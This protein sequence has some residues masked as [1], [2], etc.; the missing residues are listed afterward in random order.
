MKH[1]DFADKFRA[2]YDQATRLYA[3]G[4]TDQAAYFTTDERAF[5]AANGI[6]V[7]AMYDYA[8]D[9]KNYGEPGYDRALQIETVR[10]DYFLN[11]QHG[12]PSTAVLDAA[13]MPAKTDAVKGI[14][15][16]PRLI[17]KAK[18][19]LRGELPSSLMYSCGGDRNFFKTHDILPAEFLALVWRNGDND[20]ATVDWVVARSAAA[21]AR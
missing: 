9:Q 17:P 8:E 7:Q 13:K 18:A 6:S 5:L 15:W 11:V 4:Q 10:R 20:A 1:Y 2:L 14:E 21:K 12:K 19:K 3:S 16:L